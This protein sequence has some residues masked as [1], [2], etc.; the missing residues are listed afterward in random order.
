MT[1]LDQ[2]LH[3]QNYHQHLY[4]VPLLQYSGFKAVA[5][6]ILVLN[7]QQ[8]DDQQRLRNHIS[9]ATNGINGIPIDRII[10][11]DPLAVLVSGSQLGE[12]GMKNR[13]W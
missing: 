2:P 12:A 1:V 6:S 7:Q 5:G 11:P 8:M 4:R 10:I 9:S 13:V 3:S